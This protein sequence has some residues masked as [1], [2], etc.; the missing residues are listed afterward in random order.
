MNQY[1]HNFRGQESHLDPPD[2]PII[3]NNDEYLSTCCTANK[4]NDMNI[5]S[6]CREHATF[7][8]AKGEIE[9]ESTRIDREV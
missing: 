9:Y 4:W 1:H 6:N 7:E 5:C 8:N 3:I 2:E